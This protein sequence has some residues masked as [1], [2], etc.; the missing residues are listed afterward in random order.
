MAD[1]IGCGRFTLGPDTWYP[2]WDKK[3]AEPVT[4]KIEAPKEEDKGGFWG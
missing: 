3:N 4:T 1:S 2:C